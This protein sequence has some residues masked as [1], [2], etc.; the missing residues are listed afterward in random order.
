ML[1]I[2]EK[3]FSL[4]NAKSRLLEQLMFK[5]VTEIAKPNIKPDKQLL[6]AMLFWKHI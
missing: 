6:H 5:E 2:L 1:W 4:I 3:M